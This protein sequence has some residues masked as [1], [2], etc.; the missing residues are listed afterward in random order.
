MTLLVSDLEVSYC[1]VTTQASVMLFVSCVAGAERRGNRSNYSRS[2]PANNF[3]P[4]RACH[5]GYIIWCGA[6]ECS[7]S[8]F[9]IPKIIS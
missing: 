6:V 7:K 4:F 9:S 3:S 8:E 2:T 5:A 1:T